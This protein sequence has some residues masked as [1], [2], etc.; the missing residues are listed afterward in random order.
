MPND[1][2][3]HIRVQLTHQEMADLIGCARETV[4]TTVGQFRD[5]GLIGMEARTITILKPELLSQLVS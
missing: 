1:R 2:Q 5:Q 4:S 3:V